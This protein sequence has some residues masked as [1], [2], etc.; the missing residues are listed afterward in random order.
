MHFV[1]LV[2]CKNNEQSTKICFITSTLTLN[3]GMLCTIEI[4]AATGSD[5]SPGIP[6]SLKIFQMSYFAALNKETY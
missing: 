2:D 6:A 3:S 1:V 5:K 4:S